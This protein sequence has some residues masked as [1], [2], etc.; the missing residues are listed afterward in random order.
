MNSLFGIK[1][2]ESPYLDLEMPRMQ[3]SP[4]FA[5]I[6]SPEL[7]AETNRWMREFFGTYRPAYMIGGSLVTG[8]RNIAMLRL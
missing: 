4:E 3:V 8:A 2:I 7:V 1:V 5:R 6:Q